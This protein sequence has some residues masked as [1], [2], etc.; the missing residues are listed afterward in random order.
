MPTRL[1]AIVA[2]ARQPIALVLAAAR[3]ARRSTRILT[4]QL[5]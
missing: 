2:R 4:T 3:R 1:P 5:M